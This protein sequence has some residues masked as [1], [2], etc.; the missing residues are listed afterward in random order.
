MS[1]IP[2]FRPENGQRQSTFI[3]PNVRE[4]ENTAEANRTAGTLSGQ[5]L[6]QGA[7]R[8]RKSRRTARVGRRKHTRGAGRG[9]D[10]VQ[11]RFWTDGTR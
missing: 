9:G 7:N 5:K 10:A 3:N 11:Q 6:P 8:K 4:V 1:E 2:R